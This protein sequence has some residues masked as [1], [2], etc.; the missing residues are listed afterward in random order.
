[1]SQK[2]AENPKFSKNLTQSKKM[3]NGAKTAKSYTVK[4]ILAKIVEMVTEVEKIEISKNH[5]KAPTKPLEAV[6]GLL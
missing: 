5:P 3:K 4:A 6:F 1:M 2:S